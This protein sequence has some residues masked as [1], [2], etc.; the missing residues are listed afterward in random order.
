[1]IM[2]KKVYLQPQIKCAPLPMENL[3]ASWS[4]PETESKT[5]P[6]NPP[7]GPGNG[8]LGGKDDL[9]SKEHFNDFDSWDSWD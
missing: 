8:G 4:K 9:G 3:L 6:D 7:I 5:D 1:M 2:N